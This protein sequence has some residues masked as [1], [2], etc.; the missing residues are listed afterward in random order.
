MSRSIPLVPKDPSGP[1]RVLVMGRISTPH[2]DKENIEA[3]YRYVEDFLKHVHQGPTH[4]KHLGEQGS[5][6]R[7]DRAT[8]IEAEEEIETG[9]WD[10]VITEDLARF[11]RNPRYQYAFVQNAVDKGTRVICIGD[12]LDTAD[13]NWEVAM[14]AATLRHGLHIPDTRRRVRRTATHAFHRGGMVQ[15]VRFGYR[16]LTQ[17]EADSGQFGPKGLRIVKVPEQTPIIREMRERIMRGDHYEAVADWLNDNGVSPGPHVKNGKWTGK[18]V[19]D[20]LRDP[21]LCGIRTFRDTLYEPVFRT[22]KHRRRKNGEP[23]TEKYPE[24]AHMS[25]DEYRELMTVMDARAAEHRHLSGH[26]HPLFNKPRSR[27]IWPGQHA[28]CAVCGGMMY[29]YNSEWLK[30]QNAHEH[31]A[32]ACW[33]HV[34]VSCALTQEKVL[35]WLVAHCDQFPGFRK[36]MADAAWAELQA[37]RK[38]CDRSQSLVEQQVAELDKRAKN[39]AKAIAL[40][41]E[42]EVLVQQLAEVNQQLK[43]AQ[44]KKAAATRNLPPS[45]FFRSRQEIEARLDEALRAVAQ[46]SPEFADVMRSIF[47]V[48]VIQPIQALDSGQVRPRAWLVFRPAALLVADHAAKTDGDIDVQLD[49]FREPEHVCQLQ[50]CLAER[51]REPKP[52]LETIAKRLGLNRM[53]VK[54]ALDVARRMQQAGCNEPYR[55]LKHR[56]AS[57]S[58]WKSHRSSA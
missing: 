36:T 38:R 56:P 54:R 51:A 8:I 43:E 40:G 20:N 48:F 19:E 21:I 28:R 13:E 27:T 35:A 31:G 26:R 39:L 17:E 52:S 50:R 1:L 25:E 16:K 32:G 47:P 24:L 46:S 55:V 18:L 58:R 49:L 41:G 10:V 15:R 3:S 29:R 12:N 34:Q 14:G 9:T 37:Q 53:T 7:T 4:I 44:R 57:A 45:A 5:G 6:M 11:Y 33:N 2:Q 30:C 22:G 42:M 23:E